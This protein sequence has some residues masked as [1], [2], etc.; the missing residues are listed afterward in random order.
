[1]DENAY[2]VGGKMLADHGS[3][4]LGSY[5]PSLDAKAGQPALNR[6]A[7]VGRMWV[8]VDA[9]TD[10]ERY[11]PKYPP[12]LPVLIAGAIKLG[13]RDLAY[14]ISP[15]LMS[16]AILGMYLVSRQ[17][18][19]TFPAI[20]A[21]LVLGTSP[22]T[23]QLST[24]PTSHATALFLVVWGMYLLL[25]WWRRGSTGQAVLA[26]LLL[27]CAVTLRYTEA[28][29]ILPIGLVLFFH[30][31][32]RHRRLLPL[33]VPLLAGWALPVGL[34]VLSNLASLGTLTG[35]DLAHESTAFAWK[36][37]A[38]NWDNMLRQLHTGGLFLFFPLGLVGL[39]AMSWWHWR[40]ALVLLAWALPGT[41]VYTA[42]YWGPDLS[43]PE[44]QVNTEYLRFFLTVLPPLSI[45]GVWLLVQL[46]GGA[47]SRAGLRR[48]A[49][50]T[51]LA[52]AALVALAA[53]HN[54]SVARNELAADLGRRLAL[55]MV[56]QDVIDR[57]PAQSLV[58]C[59][60]P[61]LLN[62]L[63]YAGDYNL[64]SWDWQLAG[65]GEAAKPSLSDLA[66]ARQVLMAESLEA[67]RRVF[68]LVPPQAMPEVVRV[69]D[70]RSFDIHLLST[71]ALATESGAERRQDAPLA[72]RA[73]ARGTLDATGGSVAAATTGLRLPRS[74]RRPTVILQIIEVRRKPPS[75]PE[76]PG[77][78]ARA[79][80]EHNPP[81]RRP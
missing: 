25:R 81:P 71:W 29:L 4:S 48:K 36:Y 63:Q 50:L 68:C 54:L 40:L 41:I 47:E 67:G 23:L 76:D 7:F 46:G 27:G 53:L 72:G 75:G 6:H 3:T 38:H 30:G 22:L 10:G 16:A 69:A 51:P 20:L 70:P 12:G 9:G 33:A 39:I 5:P 78:S 11:Y 42:Y 80:P 32:Q 66:C 18:L 59:R 55:R 13:G 28:L 73:G 37:F 60:S 45:S 58:F 44:G 19:A 1:M 35:Y 62:H 15:F 24:T 52:A 61:L 65:G 26:G 79:P 74:K 34:L 2:L 21:T 56:G 49:V 43:G 57:V 77:A 14:W 31:R 64:C 17:V 8:G